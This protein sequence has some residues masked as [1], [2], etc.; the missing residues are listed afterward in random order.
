VCVE[1]TKILLH[2]S[3]TFALENFATSRHRAMVALAVLCPQQVVPYL[4][5]EFYAPNYSLRH[6]MDILEVCR[7]S[8]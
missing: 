3:D 8:L 4:T 2:L 5:R 6:R 7:N 1:L